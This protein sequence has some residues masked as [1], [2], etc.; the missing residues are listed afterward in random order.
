VTAC[1][2]PRAIGAVLLIALLAGAV[3]ALVTWY[4]L[5]S[6]LSLPML[7]FFPFS[8]GQLQPGCAHRSPVFPAIT[9][10]FRRSTIKPSPHICKWLAS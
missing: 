4:Y 7:Y 8:A 3:L 1:V 10:S 9:C 2:Y 5:N 6:W